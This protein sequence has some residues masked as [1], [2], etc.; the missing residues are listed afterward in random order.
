M[1]RVLDVLNKALATRTFLVGE[2]VS[3]ADITVCCNLLQ[4]YQQ[5]GRE[6]HVYQYRTEGHEPHLLHFLSYL[7]FHS[8]SLSLSAG[9][10]AI[11]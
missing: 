3:L 8:P 7:L 10:R 11:I 1:L 2:R 9:V 6:S 5:V 4:L